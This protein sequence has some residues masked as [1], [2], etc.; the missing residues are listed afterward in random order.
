MEQKNGSRIAG[1][2]SQHLK[3]RISRTFNKIHQEN[4]VEIL[5]LCHSKSLL[6]I[7]IQSTSNL[8]I[9][10]SEEMIDF[11]WTILSQ[12]HTFMVKNDIDY[13]QYVKIL[14]NRINFIDVKCQDMTKVYRRYS[15]ACSLFTINRTYACISKCE[16]LIIR[17]FIVANNIKYVIIF[18][19]YVKNLTNYCPYIC[20]Q[21]VKDK[22][23]EENSLHH[24]RSDY[25]LGHIV[26]T[27]NRK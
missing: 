7:Y 26:P 12:L 17:E 1:Y 19:S 4:S 9:L 27:A 13:L 24:N 21:F 5:I 20:T 18:T 8:L 6:F 11:L 23:T 2:F 22:E 16:F 10:I 14:R 25:E 3:K 15:V